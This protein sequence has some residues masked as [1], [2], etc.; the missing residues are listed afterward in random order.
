VA[1][2]LVGGSAAAATVGEA[3]ELLARG[4]GATDDAAI[5][6]ALDTVRAAGSHAAPAAAE[7]LSGLLPHRAK[8]Y[9]E[10][11]KYLV[12]RLRAYIVVALSEIGVPPSAI[13]S[14]LDT[15]ANAD[16]RMMPMEIG[17]AAR[18]AGSLGK[19]GRDF[20][21]Y[22]LDALSLRIM[23]EE[24]S[25]E[26]YDQ[27]FP[28]AEATTAQREIVRALGRIASPDDRDVVDTLRQ[29]AASPGSDTLDPRLPA[30]AQRALRM[31]Q[32]ERL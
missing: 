19:R 15:L 21:P 32:G 18:A 20:A 1:A 3:C 30:E 24:F 29:L 14:L 23:P 27:E 7:T 5:A 6:A 13:P 12:V 9:R 16:E 22:L 25:L 17:A 2:L 8:L 31:I 10:R 26:R 4:D 28:A 11:D